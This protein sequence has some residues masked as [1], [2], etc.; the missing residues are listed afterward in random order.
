MLHKISG[1]SPYWEL[2][3]PTLEFGKDT[4]P[5]FTPPSTPQSPNHLLR[6]PIALTPLSTLGSCDWT[7]AWAGHGR[8]VTVVEFSKEATLL[9]LEPRS[10]TP[11]VQYQVALSPGSSGDAPLIWG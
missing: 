5:K 8:K 3:T 7:K 6:G 10:V 1:I 11:R 4:N 9:S 2:Q